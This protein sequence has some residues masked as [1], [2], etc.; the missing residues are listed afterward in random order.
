MTVTAMPLKSA[1]IVS[2]RARIKR[3]RKD[4]ILEVQ[5]DGIDEI[6]TEFPQHITI[7]EVQ[8]ELDGIADE[9]DDCFAWGDYFRK[10]FRAIEQDK[11]NIVKRIHTDPS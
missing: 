1:A 7:E 5:F 3:N 6:F 2:F 4:Q 8:Y 10:G 9:I 11:P